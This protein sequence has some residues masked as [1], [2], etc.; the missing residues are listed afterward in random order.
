MR[1]LQP[2]KAT[3]FLSGTIKSK[4]KIKKVSASY[5]SD[6]NTKTKIAHNKWNEKWKTK[7]IPLDIGYNYVTIAVSLT[8]GKSVKKKIQVNRTNKELKLNKN[9]VS[10]N[11]DDKK[12]FIHN[13]RN[14]NG[15]FRIYY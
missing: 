9:V 11:P 4:R 1:Q 7:K 10:F 8:S 5:N 15:N 13:Q 12:E 3:M 2:I 14:S 6:S